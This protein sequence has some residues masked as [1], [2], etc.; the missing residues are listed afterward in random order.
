MGIKRQTTF[1]QDTP[2][3]IEDGII[4]AKDGEGL[5]PL[6]SAFDTIDSISDYRTTINDIEKAKIIDL[7]TK[8]D[9]DFD[10]AYDEFISEWKANGGEQVLAELNQVY[11]E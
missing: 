6:V 7:I 8:T 11:G 4:T 10:T 1:L 9:I 3:F 2:Q 5:L